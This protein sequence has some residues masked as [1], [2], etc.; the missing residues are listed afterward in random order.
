[1]PWYVNKAN[2]AL[3]V[4]TVGKPKVYGEA[5]GFF[6]C[7]PVGVNAGE[8][9]DKAGFPVINVTRSCEDHSCSASI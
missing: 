4:M 7:Q 3:I 8:R 9:F 5:S 2:A 1:M 6:F